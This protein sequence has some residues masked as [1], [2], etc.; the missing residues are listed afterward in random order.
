MRRHTGHKAKR[1]PSFL[2]AFPPRIFHL[3]T[4][5]E[6]V[7][8]DN[9]NESGGSPEPF[10]NFPNGSPFPLR[11]CSQ[12]FQEPFGTFPSMYQHL[13]VISWTFPSQDFAVFIYVVCLKL[14]EV[15]LLMPF[16]T[17]SILAKLNVGVTIPLR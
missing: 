6:N 2:L 11:H 10:M 15:I 1:S 12:G 14:S 13:W 9:G 4:A 7:R 3:P 16:F 5:N 8:R 17:K